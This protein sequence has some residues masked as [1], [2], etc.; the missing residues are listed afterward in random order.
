MDAI[1]LLRK[2]HR[3]IKELF[4]EVEKAEDPK[5]RKE[6]FDKIMT[7]LKAHERIEEEIFYPAVEKKARTKQLKEIV[8]ESY[9]EHGFVDRIA[10]DVLATKP[11]DETWKAKAKI[12][13]E[14]LEHHAFE[15]EEEKLFPKVEEIFSKEELTELGTQMDDLKNE[16]L[17]EMEEAGAKT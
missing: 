16:V 12:M 8:I 15:E 1:A 17:E 6:V 9:L 2:D 4:G 10:E 13:K 14:Q 11:E 5:K 3:K 7:E